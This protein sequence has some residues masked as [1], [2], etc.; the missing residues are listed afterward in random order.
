MA[1][2]IIS[3]DEQSRQFGTESLQGGKRSL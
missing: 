1:A 2:Q 3:Y